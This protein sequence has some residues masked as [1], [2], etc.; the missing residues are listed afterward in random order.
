MKNRRA[1]RRIP[2]EKRIDA[3]ITY[4]DSL[5]DVRPCSVSDMSDQGMFVETET[6]LEKDAYVNLKI[7]SEGLL[8]KPLFVQGFVVR[9]EKKGMAIEFMHKDTEDIT[10]YF[11]YKTY[12]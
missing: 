12:R 10:N 4:N 2:M 8:E 9:T 1:S 3:V 7:F 5:K 11:S 6:V